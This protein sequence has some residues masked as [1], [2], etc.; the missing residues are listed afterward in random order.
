MSSFVVGTDHID[1]LVTAV[2]RYAPNYPGVA[3][4]DS[5][6]IGRTMLEENVQTVVGRYLGDPEEWD[7][8]DAEERS[9]LEAEAAVYAARLAGYTFREVSPMDARQAIMVARCWQYQRTRESSYDF[10]GSWS[11]AD[12]VVAGALA[13][14]PPDDFT[15]PTGP[16]TEENLAGLQDV[17]WSWSRSRVT[18]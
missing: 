11:L 2:R 7:E 4:R 3:Q 9:E 1:Y 10:P 18:G 5:T 17:Q 14:V 12:A 8:L 16:R 6:E 13:T 15:N